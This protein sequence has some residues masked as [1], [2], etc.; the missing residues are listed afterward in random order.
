V[1]LN[2]DMKMPAFPGVKVLTLG[3]VFKNIGGTITKAKCIIPSSRITGPSPTIRMKTASGNDWEEVSN[4]VE[5]SFAT[6]GS[7]LYLQVIASGTTI[8]AKGSAGELVPAIIVKVL[9]VT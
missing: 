2:G 4:G 7:E 3:P 5:H 9:E 8:S 1:E 6:A